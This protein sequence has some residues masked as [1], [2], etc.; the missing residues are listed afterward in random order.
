MD[1]VGFH[2]LIAMLKVG[3]WISVPLLVYRVAM[4]L[5]ALWIAFALLR[6]LRW[7]FRAFI[8]GGLWRKPPRPLRE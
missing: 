5:W 8:Q 1:T 2:L 7:G 4:L 3:L 6:W